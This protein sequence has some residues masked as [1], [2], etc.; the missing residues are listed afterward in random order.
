LTIVM[1]EWDEDRHTFTVD[2]QG[3]ERFCSCKV[4]MRFHPG[5]SFGTTTGTWIAHY[6]PTYERA[7][8]PENMWFVT[9]PCLMAIAVYVDAHD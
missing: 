1:E 6:K 8:S 9:S 4:T 7:T 3:D 2:V 5:P